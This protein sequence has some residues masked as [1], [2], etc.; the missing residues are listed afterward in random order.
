MSELPSGYHT[1]LFYDDSNYVRM[2]EM[3]I[4]SGLEMEECSL[5]TTHGNPRSIE[6]EMLERGI[7][8]DTFKRKNLLHSCQL[9]NP[10]LDPRGRQHELRRIMST[11]FNEDYKP[12]FRVVSKLVRR[13]ATRRKIKENILIETEVQEAIKQARYPFPAHRP[14]DNFRGSIICPYPLDI[15]TP[16][17]R[18]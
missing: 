15:L 13:T 10:L 17:H 3:Y 11:M 4:L 8:L 12:P 2:I 6:L 1:A 18:E 7:D 9:S 5:Y 16:S 14:F